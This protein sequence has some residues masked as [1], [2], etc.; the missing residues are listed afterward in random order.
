MVLLLV[1]PS[2]ARY[3]SLELAWALPPLMLQLGFGA[4]LLAARWRSALAALIVA[5]GYLILADMW[6][7]S[8]GIW[9]ISPSQTLGLNP[10]PTLVLE[11]LV[12]F[13]LTNALVIGGLTLLDEP[14]ARDRLRR[15]R[16][17]R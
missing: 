9:M 4:D 13:L 11:E 15:W 12:F 5:T 8:Q 17:P 14:V 2:Q 7:I 10:L 3:L 16:H 1:G 6:A